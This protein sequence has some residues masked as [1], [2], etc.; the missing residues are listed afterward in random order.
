[1]FLLHSPF[2]TNSG[3]N[4]FSVSQ[5]V[6]RKCVGYSGILIGLCSSTHKVD[7]RPQAFKIASLHILLPRVHI[8]AKMTIFAPSHTNVQILKGCIDYL[9]H[10]LLAIWQL[11]CLTD[12]SINLKNHKFDVIYENVCHQVW[13]CIRHKIPDQIRYHAFVDTYNIQISI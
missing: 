2:S 4:Q 1:M 10:V 12:M 6:Y 9:M 5:N 7:D 13:K 3:Q 8:C 11:L